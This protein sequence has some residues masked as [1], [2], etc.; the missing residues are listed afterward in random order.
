MAG[1]LTES[2]ILAAI[3]GFEAQKH[4]I[5]QQIA[6]L[7]AMLRGRS[8]GNDATAAQH[9][10]TFSPEALQRM[11]EAQQRRWA[12]VRGTAPAASATADTAKPGRRLTAAG[13]RA[14]SQAAKK[15]WALKRA[16]VKKTEP[17][18]MKRPTP[19]QKGP[20]RNVQAKKAAGRKRTALKAARPATREVAE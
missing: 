4:R 14:I 8:T 2:I 6:E 19:A 10:R 7:R 9:K 18:A 5:D 16:A 11:R 13:R 12:K 1:Q 20:A 15:R 3:D 17:T